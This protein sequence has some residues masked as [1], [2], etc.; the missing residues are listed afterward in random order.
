MSPDYAKEHTLKV[1]PVHE[2]ASNPMSIPISG[3]VG[4]TT[5]LGYVIFNVQIESISSYNKDQV[6]LVIKNLS[7]LGRH[8][9]IILG[10]P[11]IHRVYRQMRESELHMALEEWQHTLLSYELAQG[12]YVNSMSPHVDTPTKYPTNTGQDPMDLD[13]TVVLEDKVTIPAFAPQI[14]CARTTKT[15]MIGHCLNLDPNLQTLLKG[16]WQIDDAKLDLLASSIIKLWKE[17]SPCPPLGYPELLPGI[18]PIRNIP[19]S[20]A[21]MTAISNLGYTVTNAPVSSAM[22]DQAV[23]NLLDIMGE[24]GPS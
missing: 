10:T 13:K 17:H 14:V 8:I 16:L 3:I 24:R 5:A 18:A 11:T 19:V 15:Q 20:E 4:H 1:R 22:A 23:T 6:A 12:M 2:L 9:P 21:I 7:G